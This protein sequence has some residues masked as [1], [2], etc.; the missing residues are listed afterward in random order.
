MGGRGVPGM[1]AGMAGARL[2]ALERLDLSWVAL[3]D[4]AVEV[5]CGLELPALRRVDLSGCDMTA[6][7]KERLGRAAWRGQVELLGVR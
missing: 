6:A 1:L 5:L 3:D 7:A 4:A 2:E